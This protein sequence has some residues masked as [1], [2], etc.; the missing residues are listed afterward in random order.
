MSKY[1]WQDTY[2]MFLYIRHESFEEG[3]RPLE[4]CC[5]CESVEILKEGLTEL[6]LKTLA[7]TPYDGRFSVEMIIEENGEYFDSDEW[8]VV[9]NK[10]KNV[11][12]YFEV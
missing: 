8:W 11:I 1:P 4:A 6:I 3:D 7:L 5:E 2:V 12:E 10:A 9:V